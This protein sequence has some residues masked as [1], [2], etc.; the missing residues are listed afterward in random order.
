[1]G[2]GILR[3]RGTGT[4]TLSGVNTYSGGTDLEAG[5][6]AVSAGGQLG[7]TAGTVTFDGGN[8]G[9]TGSFTLTQPIEMNAAGTIDVV[10]GTL[11]WTGT[12]SGGGGI[13][14]KEGAGTLF[15]SNPSNNNN[16]ASGTN[17]TEGILAIDASGQLGSGALTF[18]GSGVTLSII[19]DV[20]FFSNSIVMSNAGVIDVDSTKT[21]TSTG[22]ITG[23]GGIL[24]KAGDGTLD[25]SGGAN[26]YS[27]G[28]SLD[29]GIIKIS[30]A[31]QL[32]LSTGTLTFN[33]GQL[34]SANTLSYAN[35][36]ALSGA[37]TIDVPTGADLT[38][39]GTISGSGGVL[40]KAG[41]GILRLSSLGNTYDSGTSLDAGII[42]ISTAS[43]LGT[44]TATTGTLTFNGGQ[45]NAANTLSYA[46]PIEMDAAGTID[47][48]VGGNLTWS[49]LISDGTGGILTK[50]GGGRLILSN[51]SNSYA[52]GTDLDGGFLQINAAG[53]LG[54]G[55]LTFGGGDL[56]STG[57][58]SYD[59]PIALSSSGAIDIT[60][61]TLT[62]TGTI[63]G[64]GVLTKSGSGNLTLSNPNPLGN[65]YT[66]GTIF[67]AGVI[68]ITDDAPQ[69]GT[70]TLTF[71]GGNSLTATGTFSLTNDAIL[72]Q[73]GVMNV[74]SGSSL[75]WGGI[76][77]GA[78]GSFTKSGA[79]DL[80]LTGVNT[81]TTATSITGGTLELS[82]S[83]VI[84]ASSGVNLST[85]A[86]LEITT[87]AGAKTIQN[88]TGSSGCF[89]ELNDNAL[90]IDQNTA[91]TNFS[92]VISGIGG[93][94]VKEG[95]QT[96]T[97]SS[98]SGNTYTGGTSIDV[99]I[100]A[101]ATDGQLGTGTL[102]FGGG[103]LAASSI[104]SYSNVIELSSP[105]T[106]DVTLSGD[107]TWTGTITGAGLL[108]KEGVGKL[109]L[110]STSSDYSGG[111]DLNG[112]I[113]AISAPTQ[114]GAAVGT[115]TFNGGTLEATAAS[116]TF[117][118]PM[119]MTTDGI[120]DVVSGDL[121]WDGV[122][123]G[124]GIL[125]KNG[126]G[127]LSLSSAGNTYTGGTRLNEGI[128]SIGSTGQLG[129]ATVTFNSGNLQ[130][131][132][133]LIGVNAYSNLIDLL[134]T[135]TIIVD[136]TKTLE[137]TG[138]IEGDGLGTLVKEGAGKLILTAA[139][140]Y[141]GGTI[142]SAGVL[143]GN[144]VSLQGNILNNAEVIFDQLS[145]ICY[146]TRPS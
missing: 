9:S 130:A 92:G 58:F 135:G 52:S 65:S 115:L 64:S 5:V 41:D 33:G 85:G 18:S 78:G 16:Y 75:T 76:I 146:R 84:G 88:L 44:S 50:E 102:T 129:T 73:A 144:T 119:L 100:I 111:T 89:I 32:G 98:P 83:G 71:N 19:D 132:E 35:P 122:I 93:S 107:L 79:G 13:L 23:G 81:Y 56:E 26:N 108:T 143:Q 1:D 117:S 99:G 67:N 12:I 57:T 118:N 4:V 22:L 106:I 121:G 20:S 37:G 61:G 14:T 43:Q 113:I 125:T 11:T 120:I 42:E 136:A 86:T 21:L 24:T 2:G 34:E 128:I 80:I 38:W 134:T 54:T 124:A 94:I 29:A 27:A 31:S 39:T 63:S 101:I 103:D 68:T 7:D 131:T 15:V 112:G 17:L 45:L 138:V 145:C 104:L 77:S 87:G 105:G 59:N 62:W 126:S 110:S 90:T 66:G 96:L 114:L 140:T 72:T 142:V 60:A 139:N 141:D 6:I 127:T 10:S 116:G 109:T 51:G 47:V 74:T 133:D 49:G 30:A 25:L 46:N 28:T 82:G 40:T 3:K 48:T 123:S 97:L 53:E 36:I 91:V 70:G 95:A 69:L 8:L 55:T 137:W